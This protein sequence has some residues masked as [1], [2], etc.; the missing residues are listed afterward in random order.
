MTSVKIYS[1][2][3]SMFGAKVEIA[4]REKAIEFDLVMVPFDFAHGYAPKHPEVLRITPS[5]K[6]PC[7]STATWKYLTPRRSLS[8]WRTDGQNRH[9]GPGPLQGEPKREG[10]SIVLTKCSSLTSFN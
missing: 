4:A 1:G 5:G 8:T 7:S 9:C 6:C 2:P 3:L 10:S